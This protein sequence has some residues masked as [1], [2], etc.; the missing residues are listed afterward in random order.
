MRKT[1]DHRLVCLAALRE[2][3]FPDRKHPRVKFGDVVFLYWLLEEHGDYDYWIE[4]SQV[5]LAERYGIAHQTMRLRVCRLRDAGA[6][7]IIRARGG[8]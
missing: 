8:V 6:I 4:G 3:C 1:Y 2:H 7:T 5:L